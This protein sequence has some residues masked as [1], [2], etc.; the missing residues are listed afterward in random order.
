MPIRNFVGKLLTNCL[1]SRT[2]APLRKRPDR[3]ARRIEQLEDRTV[4]S[5]AEFVDPHPAAGNQFGAQVV[6]LS[7]G[8][9]VVTSPSDDAGGTDAGAVYLF[10]GSTGSLISTLTGSHAGDLSNVVITVLSDGNYVVASPDWDNGGVADAGAATWGSGAAGVS[11]T[12]SAANS[13]VGTAASDQV[14]GGGVTALSDGNYVVAS[15]LW[16]NG[17]VADAGAAT[18]GSGTAGVSGSIS[19]ANSLVGTTAGDQVGSGGVVAMSDGNYVVAS[20]DWD[21]GAV[22]DAG[23]ATWGR[24]T[25]GVSGTISAANSLV[26]TT[27]GDQVGSGGVVAMSDGNYVV[28][29]PDWDNGAV[30]DVGAAT[31]G[32]GT[33]GVSGMIS[34]ANSLVGTT[35]GD[36]VGS[37][38]LVD[39]YNGEPGVGYTPGDQLGGG[40]VVALANGNYVVASPSWNTSVGAVTWGSGAAG[41]T[42]AVSAANSL[43]GTTP[44]TGGFQIGQPIAPGDQVGGGGVAALAD[45]NYVVVSPDWNSG[46][47]AATW[48]NGS[49]G[50]VGP[51]S[52]AN[53]LVGT[54]PG[55]LPGPGSEQFGTTG[56]S[57]G[58]GG[59]VALADGNY[60]VASPFWS[61]GAAANAGAVTWGSGTAGV[62]GTISAANSLVGATAGDQVGSGGVAAL[63]GGNYVVASPFWSNGGLANAGAATWGSGSGGTVGPVSA[64]N[65]LVG[66]TANDEVGGLQ[67]HASGV[68]ALADGNYVVASPLWSNGGSLA[69]RRLGAVTFGNG[70]AGVAGAVSTANSLVGTTSNDEVGSGGVT[71]LADG[72]YVVASPRWDNG[73]T[74]SAGAATFGSGAA[75]VVGP[76]SV[77]NSLVGQAANTGLES[78]VGDVVNNQFYAPFVTEGGGRVRTD[79][80]PTITSGGAAAFQVGQ[81][82]AFTVTTAPGSPASVTLTETGTLPAGVTFH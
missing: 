41:I 54:T 18:W 22:A 61:N 11:G 35:A 53:S 30:A 82:G 77:A 78:V 79:I 36:Q 14:G 50:T 71:A 1:R 76:V 56:D 37:G 46:V 59:V 20:P 64:A 65:S 32:S 12:I 23:A 8:N 68:V 44:R 28:A 2:T 58:A 52:A 75:G 62:S 21:N 10:S 57:V 27:A 63:V 34:A 51:V 15:P 31:W 72:N 25:A 73:G 3:W 6:P 13:L 81:P 39:L 16:D 29:S 74:A 60:V 47:G 7:T 70:A 69:S 55:T 49:G 80:S 33:A 43:V 48:G 67:N 5:F 4:P 24:G 40:G 42:G 45:G 17:A 19:T 26:G 66:T 9:V 38:G